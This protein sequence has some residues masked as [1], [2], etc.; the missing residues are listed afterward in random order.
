PVSLWLTF[1]QNWSLPGLWWGLTIGMAWAVI[2][3]SYFC[4]LTDWENEV[5]RV[6][7]PPSS[8]QGV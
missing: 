5:E 3:G 8:R 6:M 4:M 1:K 7:G 2:L